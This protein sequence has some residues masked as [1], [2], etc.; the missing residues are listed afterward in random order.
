MINLEELEKEIDALLESETTESLKKWV[1]EQ[2]NLSVS[3]YLGNG[4]F[5][6]LTQHPVSLIVENV[7]QEEIKPLPIED[8]NSGNTQYATAA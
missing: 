6:P 7:S 5:M 4:D 3:C 1:R 8:T 2:N